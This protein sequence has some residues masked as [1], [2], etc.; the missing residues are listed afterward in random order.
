MHET[1]D[2]VERLLGAETHRVVCGQACFGLGSGDLRA[3]VVL[4]E[5]AGVEGDRRH[6]GGSQ[7]QGRPLV[8]LDQI[9]ERRQRVVGIALDVRGARLVD[10]NER[11]RR[12]SVDQAERDPGIRRVDERSLAFDPEQLASPPRALDDEAFRGAGEEVRDD[13]V[14]GDP[15]A[16][17]RDPSLAGRDEDG[18]QAAVPG[19]KVEL[20]R[21]RLLADR[22][23][24]ADGED[25]LGGYLE[26]LSGRDAEV[27]GRLAQVTELDAVLLG[28]R[29]QLRVL[30]DELV[31]PALEVEAGA[32]RVLQEL[33]PGQ[34]EATALGRDADGR[35]GRPVRERFVDGVQLPSESPGLGVRQAVS[36]PR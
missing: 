28:E 8:E 16:R 18:A 30:A 7:Q 24:G 20:D 34:R 13:G 27:R 33:A 19:G 22:A 12:T 17:D 3:G 32:D 21:D 9:A 11:M 23:V 25:D 29:R 6:A 10:E 4:V 14:D 1:Q 5:L 36:S 2:G 31:E 15:P 26:V 35:G